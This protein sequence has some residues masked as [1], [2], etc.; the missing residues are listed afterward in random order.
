M[1]VYVDAQLRKSKR[2]D[3]AGILREYP[4]LF[5]PVIKRRSSSAASFSSAFASS[6]SVNESKQR[7]EGQLRY[8]TAE[9]CSVSSHL[10]DFVI[11]VSHLHRPLLTT[12]RRGWHGALHI[13]AIVSPLLRRR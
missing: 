8:W 12:A 2:F 10:F 1:V 3:A 5:E 7:D 9:M 4:H 13:L 11:T 6:T